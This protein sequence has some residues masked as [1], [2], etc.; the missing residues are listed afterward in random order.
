MGGGGLGDSGAERSILDGWLEAVGVLPLVEL[1][2]TGEI[3]AV[4]DTYCALVGRSRDELIG[5]SPVEFTHP[6]DL[7]ATRVLLGTEPERAE[8]GRQ[9][10]KRYLR[11]DGTAIWVRVTVLWRPDLGRMFGY[12]DDIS[13]VVGARRRQ[14]ALIQHTADP[15]LVIGADGRLTDMN[16]A[17]AGLFGDMAGAPALE[18]I[19][20]RLDPEAIS[21]AV[22]ELGALFDR[23]GLHEPVTLAV[24]TDAGNR[25]HL[26][27]VADNQL[28]D[29]A[30]AGIVVSAR[31]VTHE[32]ER[33]AQAARHQKA[34]VDAL[35]RTTE[36][37][38][39]YTAGH[40]LH[41]ADLSREIGERLGLSKDSVNEIVLGASLHDLGKVAVPAEIL[42][43]PGPL[44]AP[45]RDIMRSHPAVGSAILDASGLPEAILDIVLHHHER[46]DGSGYPDGLG[47]EELSLHSRIVAV[48]DVVD[49]MTS[50]RPY[51]PALGV[52][53]ARQELE[54]NSGRRYDPDVVGA[55]LFVLDRD[56]RGR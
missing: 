11:P 48:A 3:V 55:A 18:A 8:A 43:R 20:A 17:A 19:M 37:R 32:T 27:L 53:T 1:S 16:P 24:R 31:D 34:L 47:G 23:P 22:A 36:F 56:G 28:D 5:H 13:G 29:P 41:V 45:E 42:A 39:P 12:A 4:N 15:I 7:V 50:H 38:D 46:L 54:D 35:V 30:I 10:E 25:V 14:E 6:D 49:A 44:S 2:A 9:I 40:Q 26:R 21:D 33:E 52:E 51:R